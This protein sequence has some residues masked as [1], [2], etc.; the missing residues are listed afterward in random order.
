MGTKRLIFITTRIF[1]PIDSGRKVSLYHYCRL[2]HEDYGYEI[3]I[4]SFLEAGQNDNLIKHK[5]YFIHD[6]QIAKPINKFTKLNN[7]FLKSLFLGWPLQNAVYFS[8]T[9]NKAIREYCKKVDPD[10]IIVD[11]IRLAPYY[12]AFK[13]LNCKKILDLD[14]LLSRRYERQFNSSN[15]NAQILGAYSNNLGKGSQQLLKTSFLKKMVLKSESIRVRK[16]E[17]KYGKIYDK[18]IFVSKA[19]TDSFNQVLPNKAITIR[20]GV[21]YNYYSQGRVVNSNKEQESLVFLGNLK[22]AANI[23]SLDAICKYILPG[24][25]FDYKLYVI[26]TAP[27]EIKNKFNNPKIV[28]CG[29]VEDVR[30]LVKKCFLFLSPIAYGTGI[31]TKILEAMAM[32][33]PVITNSVGIEGIDAENGVHLLVEDDYFSL[34]K[35]IND[36]YNSGKDLDYIAIN[37]QKLIEEKYT[38]ESISKDFMT[39]V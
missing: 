39:I 34:T 29:M 9:N 28:F 30:P 8:H 5:P 19:E 11:M 20:L 32:G 27:I 1:W 18:V 36:I 17:I 22:V 23:D 6:V 21:D 25:T 15:A 14:D 7:L 37:G 2:L 3:Y 33:I 24:L 10:I 16:A 13:S 26:G 31:K 4:Y 35:L 38:W 12:N